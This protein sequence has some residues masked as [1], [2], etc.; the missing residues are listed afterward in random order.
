MNFR[1]A[2][3]PLMMALGFFSTAFAA[4]G[5][6]HQARAEAAHDDLNDRDWSAVDQYLENRQEQQ[7]EQQKKKNSPS[8]EVSGDVRTEYRYLSERED[9]LRL[10]PRRELSLNDAINH[11]VIP[12]DRRRKFP[13]RHNDFDIEVN[14]KFE[15]TAEKTWAFAQIQFD[16]AMGVEENDIDSTY[17]PE[18]YGGSGTERSLDLKRAY[19]GYN[20]YEKGCHRI[21]LEV[22]RRRLYDI[23]DSKIQFNSRFD[24]ILLKFLS[25]IGDTKC[26]LFGAGIVVDEKVNHFAY[27]TELGFLDIQNSGFDLKYS[28][29]HW[30][31]YSYNRNYGKRSIFSEFENG[32]DVVIVPRENP[33]FAPYYFH[34][35]RGFRFQNS[36]F[37]ATF[38]LESL[39]CWKNRFKFSGLVYGGVIYNHNAGRIK[40]LTSETDTVFVQDGEEIIAIPAIRYTL[41]KHKKQPWAFYVGLTLGKVRKEGDWS[42]DVQYQWLGANSIPDKDATGI[43]RG[44]LLGKSFNVNGRGATNYRGWRF[45]ALYAVT[46]DLTLDSIVE[47]SNALDSNI[48]GP[49]HYSKFELEAIYAF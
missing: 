25:C 48:G 15:F 26:Y 47:F 12:A 37:T 1:K 38:H 23:F 9:H 44:N 34:D 39:N 29:I 43:G 3:L 22:G 19:W 33:V 11:S 24:G 8:L 20:I 45:E 17:D 16:N 49:H 10:R 28:Y 35:P 6:R 14:L 36:Q 2:L 30:N 42:V 27:A 5:Q 40:Y 21:D 7:K 4:E 31:N 13:I 46:D 41:R 18:G 32:N